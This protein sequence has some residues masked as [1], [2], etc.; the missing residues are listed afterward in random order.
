VLTPLLNPAD[1]LGEPCATFEP[2]P[3][4][5]ESD[6]ALVPLDGGALARLVSA[7]PATEREAVLASF[8]ALCLRQAIAEGGSM[9][10]VDLRRIACGQQ[11]QVLLGL[12]VAASGARERPE[13]LRRYRLDRLARAGAAVLENLRQVALR[14]RPAESVMTPEQRAFVR[15]LLPPSP[16]LDE[17][18]GPALRV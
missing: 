13:H 6:L 17:A 3:E 14:L 16:G 9:D 4:G 5:V 15:S 10:L 12:E 8:Q 2:A 18:G 1:S 7:L 11:A